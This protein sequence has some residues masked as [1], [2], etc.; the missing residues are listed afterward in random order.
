MRQR[1]IYKY[2]LHLADGDEHR[3][4]MPKDAQ[5]LHI[6][7]QGN[8]ICIW[9]VV[10]P[11]PEVYNRRT[12][13]IVGTGTPFSHDYV[14]T[15]FIGTVQMGAYVWHIFERLDLDTPRQKGLQ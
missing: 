5:I 15:P 11:M 7:V 2:T 9:A 14:L 6:G 10:N 12:F 8:D 4:D 1:V 3:I 13:F